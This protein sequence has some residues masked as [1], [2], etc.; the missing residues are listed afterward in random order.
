[1]SAR[2]HL[3][4]SL[5][6]LSSTRVVKRVDL[7]KTLKAAAVK[8]IVGNGG[9]LGMSSAKDRLSRVTATVDV[10]KRRKLER[11]NPE[12]RRGEKSSR[13]FGMGLSWETLWEADKPREGPAVFSEAALVDPPGE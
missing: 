5:R 10:L 12:A 4:T 7:D 6:R 13:T 2:S 1:M 11:G 3:V 8:S 9:H